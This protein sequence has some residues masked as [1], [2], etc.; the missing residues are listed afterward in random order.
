MFEKYSYNFLYHNLYF[1]CFTYFNLYVSRIFVGQFQIY[2]FTG[3][4]RYPAAGYR[5]G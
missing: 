4:P 3:R 1:D 2:A 5:N